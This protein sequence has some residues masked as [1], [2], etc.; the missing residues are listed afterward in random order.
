MR[1]FGSLLSLL[2]LGLSVAFAA[3]E[4]F[5]AQGGKVTLAIGADWQI[6]PALW[7][8]GG[9]LWGSLIGKAV[10]VEKPSPSADFEYLFKEKT[11]FARGTVRLESLGP[12]K[13]RVVFS[14]NVFGG[15]IRGGG[16]G[17]SVFFPSACSNFTWAVNGGESRALHADPRLGSDFCRPVKV[18]ELAFGVREGTLRISFP[19]SACCQYRGPRLDSHSYSF[20]FGRTAN[21][22]VPQ[23]TEAEFAVVLSLDGAQA[24]R[25]RIVEPLVIRAG[26]EW[27]PFDYRKDIVAGSAADFS[28]VSG[29]DAPAGKYG[30]LKRDG[31]RFVFEGRPDRTVRFWGANLTGGACFPSNEVAAV[32][33]ADRLARIGYNSVRI[34]HHDWGCSRGFDTTG[35]L[36][37]DNMARLDRLLAEC[38]RRGIYATTDL[39]VS[40]GVPWSSIGEKDRKGSVGHNHFKAYVL[41]H[42]G[43]YSN[44]CDFAAKFLRHV[45]P[46]TGRAYKDEPA[47]GLISLVNEGL[48][49][50]SWRSIVREPR[51]RR[52]WKEWLEAERAKDPACFPGFSP[53]APP[54]GE[55]QQKI[56]EG[57][58]AD[59]L[60]AFSVHMEL[61]FYERMSAFLRGLGCK[62]L[63]TD[64]NFGPGRPGMREMRHAF[65]YVDTHFYYEHPSKRGGGVSY[66]AN[67][68]P[69]DR[70][71]GLQ[72]ERKRF[73][74]RPFTMSEY[75]WSAPCQYRAIGALLGAGV[76]AGRDWSGVWRFAYSQGGRN[77]DDNAGRLG[78]FDAATD[79]IQLGMERAA[80]ALYLRGDMPV[81]KDTGGAPRL[82]E[83]KLPGLAM[84][85]AT[86]SLT[87]DT[88][89]TAGGYASE[90]GEIRTSAMVFRVSRSAAAVWASSLDG[91]PLRQSG[92]IALFHLTDALGDG[93]TF[94]DVTRRE[95]TE[96]GQGALMRRGL[97]G[98][99]LLVENPEACAV[100]ALDAVG[101]RIEK[102]PAKV[103]RGELRFVADI[104]GTHGARNQYEIV[105]Q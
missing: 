6:S 17:G 62:A 32:R 92:R 77:L 104:R 33:L 41:F 28:S 48:F 63:L 96:R 27:I 18:K 46:H 25:P 53:D 68:H 2:S 47:L 31:G 15:G 50:A 38:F 7:G 34:H 74:D 21:G 23:G 12:D 30:W 100:Y 94:T 81:S 85:F 26:D 95:I 93:A 13:I 83:M 65:D 86:G 99:R 44:Y 10:P 29:L 91:K 56:T 76:A 5:L 89:R 19:E 11:P 84:D 79:P 87:V 16:V 101:N 3:D 1:L 73:P 39:F 42:E 75:N 8:N 105:R 24:L 88:E 80:A 57:P 69:F 36:S 67:R 49:F 54:E 102:L 20:R 35:E 97:A 61:R 22:T 51:L 9:K 59:V 55:Y 40:R 64:V 98:I 37:A 78:S 66:V 60:T 58:R 14:H 90:G 70:T 71:P 103:V 72:F 4:V 43:A 52:A 45:N 82:E